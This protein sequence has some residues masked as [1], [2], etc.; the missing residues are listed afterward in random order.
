MTR[1]EMRTVMST[2]GKQEAML[3]RTEMRTVM[4]TVVSKVGK[5]EAMDGEEYSWEAG[6]NVDEDRGQ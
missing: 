1:T 4:S 3:M 6:S 5:Q 2:V